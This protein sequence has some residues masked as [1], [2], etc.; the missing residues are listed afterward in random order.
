M[1]TKFN[2][3]RDIN[4]YNG[5][6]LSFSDTKYAMQL[7]ANVEQTLAIPASTDPTY[8]NYL[9]IFSIAPGNSAWIS[10][11]QT[12]TYPSGA[13]SAISSE[14]NPIARYIKGD[15]LQTLHFITPDATAKLGITLYAVQ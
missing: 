3:V 8:P 12:A 7:A 6:G 15:G 14:L 11:N 10:L 9:A 1:T 13:V 4:G 2:L 5:F